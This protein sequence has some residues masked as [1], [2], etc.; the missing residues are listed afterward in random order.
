MKSSFGLFVAALALLW[1]VAPADARTFRILEGELRGESSGESMPLSGEFE[2]DPAGSLITIPNEVGIDRFRIARFE[3]QSDGESFAPRTAHAFGVV[4]VGSSTIRVVDSL[5]VVGDGVVGFSLEAGGNVVASSENS[6]TFRNWAFRS[7]EGNAFDRAGPGDGLPVRFDATGLLSATDV[8]Y[9]IGHE[10]CPLPMPLPLPEPPGD[11]TIIAQP[12]PEPP[13]G[14]TTIA[15]PRLR[16]PGGAILIAPRDGAVLTAVGGSRTISIANPVGSSFGNDRSTVRIAT[17]TGLTS[18]PASIALGETPPSANPPDSGA[19][20]TAVSIAGP[21]FGI[22]LEDLGI[23]APAGAIISHVGTGHVRVE[24]AGDIEINAGRVDI[25][26]LSRLT[27]ASATRITVGPR[28][29]ELPNHVDLELVELAQPPGGPVATCSSLR[30][31]AIVRNPV[32]PR[33]FEFVAAVEAPVE[34]MLLRGRRDRHHHPA[35]HHRLKLAILGSSQLDVRDIDLGSLRLGPEDAKIS[36]R[37]RRS[38]HR[39]VNR[40]GIEDLLVR[41]PVRGLALGDQEVCLTGATYHGP[42][43]AGCTALEAQRHWR[44]G[45]RRHWRRGG[46][47]HD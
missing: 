40:D 11:V 19:T 46:R 18:T 45:A 21:D 13:G 23:T 8:R 4:V 44:R 16:P 14:A 42:A 24:S 3:V 9:G 1:H 30:R 17:R 32:E 34:M 28:G 39:D 41:F 35:F 47:R 10:A 43:I 12:P 6:V 2:F 15:P 38:R 22:S 26:G 36:R 33:R 29:I 27:I 25:V 37:G 20:F 5:A 31:E 7:D